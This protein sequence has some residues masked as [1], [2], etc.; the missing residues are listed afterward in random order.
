M[1]VKD[2]NQQQR[3]GAQDFRNP[4]LSVLYTQGSLQDSKLVSVEEQGPSKW[5]LVLLSVN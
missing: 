4:V 5:E 3:V 2:F 1:S